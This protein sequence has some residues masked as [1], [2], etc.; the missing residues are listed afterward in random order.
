MTIHSFSN[1]DLQ[2][3]AHLSSVAYPNLALYDYA[4]PIAQWLAESSDALPGYEDAHR[5]TGV[6]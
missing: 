2:R 4:T 6:E 3:V 1:Y 5:P